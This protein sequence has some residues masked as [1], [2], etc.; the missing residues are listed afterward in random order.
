MQTK[1]GIRRAGISLASA[2][3]PPPRRPRCA[4]PQPQ[5]PPEPSPPA[6]AAS[7]SR[8]LIGQVSGSAY[9][10]ARTPAAGLYTIEYEVT[11]N[12]AFDTYLSGGTELGHVG[13]STGTCRTRSV[14]LPAGGVP[15]Q[16]ARPEG[17]GSASVYL[18]RI[19]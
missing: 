16:P 14:R 10:E 8:Q 4:A 13:G 9:L 1:A 17:S 6:A 2:S 15:V 18:V 12:A 3:R 19:A 11:G 5:P 7:S